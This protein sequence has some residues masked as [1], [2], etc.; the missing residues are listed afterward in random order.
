MEYI[1]DIGSFNITEEEKSFVD[2]MDVYSQ[3]EWLIQQIRSGLCGIDQII[4]N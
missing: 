4:P 3:R 1:V 2:S